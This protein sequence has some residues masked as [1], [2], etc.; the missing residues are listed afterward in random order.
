LIFFDSSTRQPIGAFV[1]MRLAMDEK[2]SS[3]NLAKANS[4]PF[5][6]ITPAS[7]ATR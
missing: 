4:V 7:A 1:S 2:R 6:A 5:P 3:Q